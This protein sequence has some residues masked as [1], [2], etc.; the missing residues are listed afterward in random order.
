MD[1][2]LQIE[3]IHQIVNPRAEDAEALLESLGLAGFPSQEQVH[4]DI[5]QKLLLPPQSFPKSWLPE[6]QALGP[7]S[8]YPQPFTIRNISTAYRADFC[9][10]WSR[11][12]RY[13]IC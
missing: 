12:A 11:G 8:I 9:S 3:L 10:C 13:R 4:R 2:G 5:E 7:P 6:F 1:V